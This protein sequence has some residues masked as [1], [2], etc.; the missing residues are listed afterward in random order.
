VL[1]ISAIKGVS[2]GVHSKPIWYMMVASW[3][4]I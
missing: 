1:Q 2:F 3:C 4:C